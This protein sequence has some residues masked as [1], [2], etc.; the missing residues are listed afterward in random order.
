MFLCFSSNSAVFSF[1]LAGI[2]NPIATF[3]A[4]AQL[5][6]YLKHTQLSK[7]LNS[8]CVSA[9]RDGPRTPDLGGKGTTAEV[10]KCVLGLLETELSKKK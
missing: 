7:A 4:V 10:L 5:L 3:L 9:V 1:V 8:V 6:E 2:A